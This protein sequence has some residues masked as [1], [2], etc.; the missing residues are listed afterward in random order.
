M[1]AILSFLAWV[2]KHAA[3]AIEQL[4]VAVGERS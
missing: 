1:V 3:R 4:T 2:L